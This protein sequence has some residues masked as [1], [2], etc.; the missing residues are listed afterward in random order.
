MSY[1]NLVDEVSIHEN[2][3]DKVECG[4]IFEDCDGY[5]VLSEVEKNGYNLISFSFG[6]T[7][8][9]KNYNLISLKETIIES[10]LTLVKEGVVICVTVNKN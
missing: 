6:R 10:E 7:Y 5:Y 8:F 9:E 4:M 2:D 3:F 1:A